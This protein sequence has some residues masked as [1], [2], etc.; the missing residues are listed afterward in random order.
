[1]RYRVT[2]NIFR[3]F[4]GERVSSKAQVVIE[5]KVNQGESVL[6]V[7]YAEASNLIDS[8]FLV[9]G[10]ASLLDPPVSVEELKDG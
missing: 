6:D 9:G 5:V 8:R 10:E 7:A 3:P 1:M 4:T 2:Y